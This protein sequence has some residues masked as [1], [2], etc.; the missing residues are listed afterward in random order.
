MKIIPRDIM[1]SGIKELDKTSDKAGS[2]T[3]EVR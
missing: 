1:S 3:T 2:K